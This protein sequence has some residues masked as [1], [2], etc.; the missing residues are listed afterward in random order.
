MNITNKVLTS[1]GIEITFDTSNNIIDTV[2]IDKT[3]NYENIDSDDPEDHTFTAQFESDGNKLTIKPESNTPPFALITILY[4]TSTEENQKITV[5][6]LNMYSLF[7]AKIIYLES[8]DP[9]CCKQCCNH[10]RLLRMMTY[11]L[12]LSLFQNSY[13]YN[14]IELAVKYYNDINRLF[15]LD[16]I[17]FEYVE[18]NPDYYS[19]SDRFDQLFDRMNETIKNTVSPNTKEIFES[20]LLCDLYSLI[21]QVIENRNNN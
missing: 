15:K 8:F 11:S 9:S 18:L 16:H 1:N 2:Y 13:N 14:N 7:K 5:M 6:F 12:R 10:A 21:F 3:Q 17:S 4:H 19:T 20:I